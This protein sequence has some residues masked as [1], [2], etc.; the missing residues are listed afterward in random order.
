MVR[1]PD[2]D[3]EFLQVRAGVQVAG[4]RGE[5]NAH[6][7]RDVVCADRQPIAVRGVGIILNTGE[8][9]AGKPRG[10]E[11]GVWCVAFDRHLAHR[12][13]KTQKQIASVSN[14]SNNVTWNL[15][16]NKRLCFGNIIVLVRG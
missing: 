9:A 12:L 8:R 3:A 15:P 16:D 6:N 4:R 5:G 10:F 1:F 13:G 11:D 14:G 7:G 2:E